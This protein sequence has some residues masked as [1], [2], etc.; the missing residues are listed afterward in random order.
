MRSLRKDPADLLSGFRDPDV[1][2]LESGVRLH[3]GGWNSVMVDALSPFS[4]SGAT[5]SPPS[6]KGLRGVPPWSLWVRPKV[7][8]TCL[9]PLFWLKILFDSYG[10][11]PLDPPSPG[12]PSGMGPSRTP[13]GI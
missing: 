6:L 11:G 13:H 4:S 1:H 10:L 3:P 9:P 5:T 8:K 12:V 2:L 7:G